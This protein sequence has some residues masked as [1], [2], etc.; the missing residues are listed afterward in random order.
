MT[1]LT[2]QDCSLAYGQTEATSHDVPDGEPL[3]LHAL[4]IQA[5]SRVLEWLLDKNTLLVGHNVAFDLAVVCAEWPELLPLVFRKLDANLVTDT[6]IRQQLIDIAAGEFRG[7]LGEDR[8]WIAY[9]YSLDAT[10]YRASG[11]RLKKDGFRLFYAFFRKVTSIEDW[12]EFAVELQSRARQVLEGISHDAQF[13]ELAQGTSKK[14]REELVKA[15]PL[16][17]IRYPLKDAS[18]TMTAYLHQQEHAAYLEDQY[19]QTRAAFWLHLASAW[20]LRTSARGVARLQLQTERACNDVEARLVEAGLVRKDGS[21]DTKAAKAWMLQVCGWH[22]DEGLGRFEPDSDESIELRLTAAGEPSLDSDACKAS[23]DLTLKEYAELT[24]LKAVLNKDV[25]AL[26]RATIY[27]VHT[28]FG[29]AETGRRTSSNPNVQNWRRLPGIREC[30]IPRPGNVFA[31]ADYSGLELATLAQAC[32]D[33]LGESALA[34]AINAGFDPHTELA[35]TILRI[36]AEEGRARRKSKD[37]IFDNAR[38]TAKVANFG[39]PGGLGAEKLVLFARKTYGV[40]MTEDQARELKRQWL[41]RWPEMVDYFAHVNSLIGGGFAFFE[42]LRS[43]RWRGGARY[44]A[45]CNSFFQGLGADAT[46]HAGWLV[47]KACYVEKDSPL[48]GARIVNY[49]HDEFIL[50]AAEERAPEVAEELSRLMVLGASEWI[51]D[52][53]L[54]AE[55]CL[56]RVWSKDAKTLRDDRGRLIPW[57]PKE[58]KVAA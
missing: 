39:F 42:Q 56:M 15:D 16:E 22:W 26:A 19:R 55:P 28:N 57:A 48:Y 1:C 10:Y 40:V 37:G 24:S 41:S 25:P 2:W 50:E 27:P 43:K 3:I 54:Q 30:F 58:E 8:K 53:K 51:P 13:E 29:L 31:Q 20:G 52:V 17:C 12:P 35:S 47:C 9:D 33:L 32:I 23:D 5:R 7:R 34:Q 49:V 36:S 11:E 44:T 45:A 21:R 46:A 18:S 6:K 14:D 4:D 38:Q